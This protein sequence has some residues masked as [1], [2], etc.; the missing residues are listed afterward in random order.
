MGY[1]ISIFYWPNVILPFVTGILID[2][3]GYIFM[4]FIIFFLNNLGGINILLICSTI[5]FLGQLLLWFGVFKLQ[6][7][8]MLVGRF[9]YGIGGSG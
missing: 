7:L 8:L 6:M 1:L 5:N 3:Y 4:W 9:C 2:K